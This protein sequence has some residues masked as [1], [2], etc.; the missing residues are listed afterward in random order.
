MR[1]S[2]RASV[3]FPPYLPHFCNIVGAMLQTPLFLQLLWSFNATFQPLPTELPALRFSGQEDV[4]PVV[5]VPPKSVSYHQHTSVREGNFRT[6][7]NRFPVDQIR[8]TMS[9]LWHYA[10]RRGIAGMRVG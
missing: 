5:V 8:S 1:F 7:R 10:G 3:I 2:F 9:Y 6:K 4:Q